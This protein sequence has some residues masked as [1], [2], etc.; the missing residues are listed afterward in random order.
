[1]QIQIEDI[2]SPRDG[3]AFDVKKY[4]LIV[5]SG[6]IGMVIGNSALENVFGLINI[7]CK[8]NGSFKK[9]AGLTIGFLDPSADFPPGSVTS[10]PDRMEATMFLSHHQMSTVSTLLRSGGA[11]VSIN[12][13]G[14]D[15]CA[16]IFNS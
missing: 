1:M 10:E 7:E 4:D 11:R 5:F 9:G 6:R 14:A 2:I 12:T 8:P 13:G 3:R 16:I 15:A